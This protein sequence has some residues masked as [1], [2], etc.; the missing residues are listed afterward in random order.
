MRTTAFKYCSEQQQHKHL[1]QLLNLFLS[2][3]VVSFGEV[4]SSSGRLGWATLFYCGFP[5][6]YFGA[7]SFYECEN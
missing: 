4:S 3:Y 2:V 1:K 5:Y 6:N 7:A